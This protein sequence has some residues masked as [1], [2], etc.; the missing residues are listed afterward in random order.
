MNKLLLKLCLFL[1]VASLLSAGRS[2]AQSVSLTTPGTAYTQNFNSLASNTNTTDGLMIPGWGFLETG[3]NANT[4]YSIGT[5][6]GTTGDTYSFGSA[7]STDRAL[8]GLRS[9]TLVPLLEPP[10][11]TTRAVP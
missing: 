6:S 7:G 2:V 8:G 5:G 10:L 9:G 3:T 11:P 1:S 4:T